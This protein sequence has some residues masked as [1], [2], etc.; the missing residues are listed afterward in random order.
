MTQMVNLTRYG[1][2]GVGVVTMHDG[3][4]ITFV[5]RLFAARQSA[6]HARHFRPPDPRGGQDAGAKSHHQSQ[7]EELQD[8][9]S[10][11]PR[12]RGWFRCSEPG[13]SAPPFVEGRADEADDQN[14][15]KT[16]EYADAD[17]QLFLLPVYLGR[18]RFPGHLAL[19]T[20]QRIRS[21]GRR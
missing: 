1:T 19:L 6:T 5:R 20:H 11:Y 21:V 8:R 13:L 9:S 12:G 10:G 14:G 16:G 2:S 15:V 17:Q 7:D 4:R 18:G 3:H